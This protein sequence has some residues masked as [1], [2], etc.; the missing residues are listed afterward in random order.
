MNNL[1]TFSAVDISILIGNV[2]EHFN[3]AIYTFLVPILAPQFFPTTD[4][5]VQLIC[6][7]GVL[8]TSLIT[9]PLGGIL[10]GLIAHTRGPAAGLSWSLIG[11]AVSC[12]L[13]GLLPTYAV[14][15]WWA[16]TLLIALRMVYGIF[17]AGESAIAKLYILEQKDADA[18]FFAS[19]IYQTAS[20][21]GI[22][23]ASAVA[24]LIISNQ[25][26]TGLIFFGVEQS[27][28][29]WRLPF[30]AAGLTAVVG[31]M[32]RNT[33]KDFTV[34]EVS[35]TFSLQLFLEEKWTVLRIACITSVSYLTYTFPFIFLNSFVPLLNPAISLR[36]MMTLNTGLL[37]FDMIS[38]PLFGKLL[39]RFSS[40]QQAASHVKTPDSSHIM[41]WSSLLLAVTFVP[42]FAILPHASLWM[43]SGIRIWMVTLGVIYLVPLHVWYHDQTDGHK[44]YLVVALGT[45]SAAATVGRLT[46]MICL[47]LWKWS[48]WVI[49]PA[50]YAAML[51]GVAAGTIWWSKKEKRG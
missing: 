50:I 16:P 7:Y 41:F 35:S 3:S 27:D 43:I 34:Q 39:K 19:Y 49:A 4:P 37:V 22:T 17:A 36:S 28:L 13:F 33:I 20:M 32:M 31:V 8:A 45:S 48:G 18:A 12:V 42:C 26:H 11:M 30:L 21:L 44:R 40:K 25:A 23:G 5:V 9:R 24:L 15:G 2:L 29:I 14:V 1:R 6:G 46:P 47:M 38:I 10:F 51:C